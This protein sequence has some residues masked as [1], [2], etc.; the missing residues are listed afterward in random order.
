MLLRSF[1]VLLSMLLSRRVLDWV[2][3]GQ[4]LLHPIELRLL[5]CGM[6]CILIL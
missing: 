4:L 3:N 6:Q 2:M 5:K 1:R